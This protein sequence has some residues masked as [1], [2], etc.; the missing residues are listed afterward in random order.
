MRSYHLPLLLLVG[1]LASFAFGFV[2]VSITRRTG[3]MVSLRDKSSLQRMMIDTAVS[4]LPSSP[5]LIIAEESWRQYVPLAVSAFVIVDILLGSPAANSILRLAQ[6]PSDEEE[7]N[8]NNNNNNDTFQKSKERID[9]QALAQAAVDRAQSVQELRNFLDAQKTD[10]DRME[11]I[12]KQMDQQMAEL[13][14]KL[15]EKNEQMK[16]E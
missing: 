10:W 8:N 6:P 7:N 3:G 1:S 5:S 11:D 13:D 15:E 14:E 9:T 4:V 2:P 16:K 12:R